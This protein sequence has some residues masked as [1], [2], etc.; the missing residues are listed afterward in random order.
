[1]STIGADGR[2]GCDEGTNNP[3]TW[4]TYRCLAMWIR[5]V[6]PR[7]RGCHLVM[8][9]GSLTGLAEECAI[10]TGVSGED[11]LAFFP[12][13]PVRDHTAR[14]QTPDLLLPG[15]PTTPQDV[16]ARCDLAYDGEEGKPMHRK[17]QLPTSLFR[18]ISL[19]AIVVLIVAA[20]AIPAFAQNSVPPTAVQAAKMPQYASRLAHSLKRMPAPKSQV[21]ARATK[22]RGPLDPSDIYDN[23]P[24]NGNTDAW[25]INFGFIVSDSFTI[26]NDQYADYRHEFRR[27]AVCRRHADLGRG[28][29]YLGR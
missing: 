6:I 12:P 16:R 5:E 7:G 27:V 25:D 23:G 15:C 2:R 8:R 3:V 4:V 14:N 18:T 22:H 20:A 19:A 17:G 26:A 9:R 29:D 24:I 10:L 11:S 21:F 13:G 1:M 28:V